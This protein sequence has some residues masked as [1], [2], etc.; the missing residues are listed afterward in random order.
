MNTRNTVEIMIVGEAVP[1]KN[2]GRLLRRVVMPHAMRFPNSEFGSWV[3]VTLTK[4]Q[5]AKAR[6]IGSPVAILDL[7]TTEVVEI[8]HARTC[9][10]KIERLAPSTE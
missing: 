8:V 10:E 5:A 3:D 6:A 2:K 7:D 4:E 9:R 1:G